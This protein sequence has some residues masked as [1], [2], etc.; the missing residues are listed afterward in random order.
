MTFGEKS[1]AIGKQQRLNC[2]ENL[3]LKFGDGQ[4]TSSMLLQRKRL[5]T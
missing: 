3:T 2:S 4:I 1:K 5:T